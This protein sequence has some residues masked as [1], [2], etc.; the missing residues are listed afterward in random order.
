MA[1]PEEDAITT[2]VGAEDGGRE[3][4]SEGAGAHGE[5]EC[6]GSESMILFMLLHIIILGP[7][8]LLGRNEPIGFE[9]KQRNTL[10]FRHHLPLTLR[11][12]N[13]ALHGSAR[14]RHCPRQ[15]NHHFVE[16]K[17]SR[18]SERMVHPPLA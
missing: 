1:S 6:P 10:V 4:E 11:T 7:F 17:V 5:G 15:I 8:S 12:H 9:S 13:A 3:A 18:W 16:F 14:A 2:S